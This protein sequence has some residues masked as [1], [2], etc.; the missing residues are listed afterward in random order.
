MKYLFSIIV[1]ADSEAEAFEKFQD[2]NI[3]P[4]DMNIEEVD[5]RVWIKGKPCV[6]FTVIGFYKETNQK[7]AGSH[8]TETISEAEKKAELLGVT[9]C[10]VFE[11]DHKAVD[12]EAIIKT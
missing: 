5:K 9:V 4:A 11:G 8:I 2:K 7:Y 3:N 10:G 6:P 12:N 1:E